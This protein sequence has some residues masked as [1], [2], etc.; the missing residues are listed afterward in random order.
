MQPGA[1][2][3]PRGGLQQICFRCALGMT[4]SCRTWRPRRLPD[5]RMLCLSCRALAAIL[6]GL[7]I[8]EWWLMLR[9]KGACR[10]CSGAGTWP[11]G[12]RSRMGKGDGRSGHRVI[13]PSDDRKSRSSGRGE[14]GARGVQILPIVVAEEIQRGASLGKILLK[15]AKHARLRFEDG[16]VVVVK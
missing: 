9:G 4:V 11:I 1:A 3:M 2:R 12:F 13:R 16:D 6:I 8:L 7:R 10:N 15:A 5:W 14:R